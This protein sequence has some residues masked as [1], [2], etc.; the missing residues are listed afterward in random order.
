MTHCDVDFTQILL[1]FVE[2]RE[3]GNLNHVLFLRAVVMFLGLPFNSVS[4][5][6][7]EFVWIPLSDGPKSPL[8]PWSVGWSKIP[9][10]KDVVFN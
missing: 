10:S 8:E 3:L 6:G 7:T 4:W 9:F 2:F 1:R 5:I